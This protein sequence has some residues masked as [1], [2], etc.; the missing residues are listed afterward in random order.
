M[1][2]GSESDIIS[3][4]QLLKALRRHPVIFVAIFFAVI[5]IAVAYI[6]R[7][8]PIYRS[9]VTIELE[10]QMSSVLGRG[11]EFYSGAGGSYWTNKNYYATQYEIIKSYAVSEKVVS[12]LPPEKMSGLAGGAQESDIKNQI[13]ALRGR[14]SV[15]PQKNSNIAR[16]SVDDSD[17]IF[18]AFLADEVTNAFLDFN[19]EKKY[20]A[21]QAAARWLLEQSINL[22]KQ[23]EESELTVFSFKK[24][25]NILS[26]TFESKKEMLSTT[27]STIS[28]QLTK[29]E[30]EWKSQQSLLSEL[31][32]IDISDPENFFISDLAKNQGLIQNLKISY[33]T[34]METYK[35][36]LNYYGE[37]HPEIIS[38]QD[39]LN[40]VKQEL[41]RAIN[42]V[43]ENLALESRTQKSAINKLKAMK[44][45]VQ[46]EMVKLSKLEI[47]YSKL[48]REVETN[49]K[50]YDMV[51]ERTKQA[52]L[53][54][55]LKANNIRVID[56]AQVSHVPIK[57]RKNIIMLIAILLAVLLSTATVL[58]IELL[59]R[60]VGDID[61][62]EQ[63][64]GKSIIGFIPKLDATLK[65]G[66]R[67]IFF[68]KTSHAAAVEAI[69][70][71]RAN[72]HLATLDNTQLT[73]L[74]TSSVPKEGKTTVAGN[75]AVA[76]AA[77]GKSVVLVDTD[78]RRPQIHR[79]F[80]LHNREGITTLLLGDSTLASITHHSS[81]YQGVD[82]LPCGPVSP[83]PLEMIGSHKFQDLISELKEKYDVVIL[84]SPPLFSVT[85]AT[86]LA[87]MVDATLIVSR[88]EYERRD[89]LRN[90]IRR[91]N[92]VDA[93]I[94]GVVVNDIDFKK[95][96]YSSYSYN[97]G[98][99]YG[100]NYDSHDDSSHSEDDA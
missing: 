59:S 2:E 48:K 77:A 54:K 55:M 14:I 35:D 65:S 75:V 60:K 6:M 88:L 97:Y 98:Y 12:A 43:K 38:L 56:R 71:L 90:S 45:S 42:G 10:P 64:T 29:Q 33:L 91:L 76:F 81:E 100:Y 62:L 36:K 21:T 70:S 25:H 30:M 57:P 16:I 28:A 34:L 63:I 52:D 46:K 17:P 53:S 40:E 96:G 84:D 95:K 8:V 13:N 74:I 7:F 27:I 72:L 50:M 1:P 22:K 3:P 24:E 44:L 4:K 31:E 80:A 89:I 83:T 19:I 20:L 93:K 39:R 37:K 49:N 68:D 32:K 69:R 82:V 87:T 73:L 86:M 58:G 78:L 9:T 41:Q 67:Q 51:L 99:N 15:I 5:L 26:T 11:A 92:G 85:D 66:A 61:E 18:A 47:T 23:L 94:I 79:M